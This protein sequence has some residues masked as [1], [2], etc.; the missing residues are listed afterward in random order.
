MRILII[1]DDVDLRDIIKMNLESESFAV[2]ATSDGERGIYLGKTNEYDLMIIDLALPRKNGIEICQE[3]RSSGNTVPIIV[4]S[5]TSELPAKIMLLDSGADDYITKPFDFAE[6]LARIRALLRRPKSIEQSILSVGDLVLN[7][8]KQ[9]VMRGER[10]IRL[11]RK[12]F[13]LLEYLMR[14]KGMVLS[15]GSIL[16]HVW[17]INSDPFSNTIESHILKLRKKIGTEGEIELIHNVPGRGYKIDI[18]K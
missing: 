13:S 6:L 7:T 2:D 16:E 5:V 3:L 14:N 15:R 8:N 12:E 4:I 11:T 18:I 10:E 9:S 1:E 17:N